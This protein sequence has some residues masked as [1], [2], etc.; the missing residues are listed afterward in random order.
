M[1]RALARIFYG[2][3]KPAYLAMVFY[4]DAKAHHNAA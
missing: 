2:Y 3:L 4:N 1:I